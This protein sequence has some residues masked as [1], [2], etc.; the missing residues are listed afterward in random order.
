VEDDTS[1]SGLITIADASA[2][3][4]REDYILNFD[5]LYSSGTITDEQ[6]SAIEDY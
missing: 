6:Y 3:K 4:A 1:A 2:N 5:Y